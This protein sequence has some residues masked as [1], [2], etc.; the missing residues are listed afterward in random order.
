MEQDYFV[1]FK[2]LNIVTF[3]N[4]SIL[5]CSGWLQMVNFHI[6]FTYLLLLGQST[7]GAHS[8]RFRLNLNTHHSSAK[9]RVDRQCIASMLIL[10]S[11]QEH[12][13]TWLLM[14]RILRLKY[15][16]GQFSHSYSFI[17][18]FLFH[19]KYFYLLEMCNFHCLKSLSTHLDESI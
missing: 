19:F 9:S 14:S 7:K 1:Y 16:L 2:T 4:S 15:S 5:V 12:K 3:L 8:V 6:L 18:F 11:M 13:S 17:S 10:D